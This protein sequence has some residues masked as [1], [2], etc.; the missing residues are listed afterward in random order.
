MQ[1]A[2]GTFRIDA[3]ERVLY[4]C[5][6]PVPLLP[7]AV[8]VLLGLLRHAPAVVSANDL[9][10]AAWPSGIA[11]DANLAQNVYLLREA[12]DPRGMRDAIRTIPRVGYRFD[13]IVERSEST[14]RALAPVRRGSTAA[15]HALLDRRDGAS[16]LHAER[17][18]ELQLEAVPNDAEA[19]AGYALATVLRIEY[20]HADANL[21]PRARRSVFRALQADP[22][23]ATALHAA[24]EIALFADFDTVSARAYLRRALDVPRACGRALHARSWIAAIDGDVVA[25]EVDLSAALACDVGNVYRASGG[26]F[27][28][29]RGDPAD[30]VRRLEPQLVLAP[31]VGAVARYYYVKALCALDRPREAIAAIE[32]AADGEFEPQMQAVR[33]YGY[34]RC[35]KLD[36]ALR[37]ATGPGFVRR[38]DRAFAIAM[39]AAGAGDAAWLRCALDAMHAVRDPWT[40]F[41]GI[42]PAFAPYRR[43]GALALRRWN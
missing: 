16:L 25:A 31:A 34:S 37:I 18:F 10:G 8:K 35:G 13:G 15:A 19:L 30:A 33:A 22:A 36:R 17:S 23:S 43:R 29:F 32:E 40:V 9:I 7:R 42:E 6:V 20:R 5:D 27:A 39:A 21:W 2:F 41:E 24:A 28:L 26:A 38:G 12:L 11:S 14:V 3:D 1:F 4:A